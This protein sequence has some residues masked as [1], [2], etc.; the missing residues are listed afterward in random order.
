MVSKVDCRRISK[1]LIPYLCVAMGNSRMC[2]PFKWQFIV[3]IVYFIINI[4][5]FYSKSKVQLFKIDA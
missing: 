1:Q 2:Q 4:V 5:A 3:K